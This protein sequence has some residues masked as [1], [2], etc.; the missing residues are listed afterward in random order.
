MKQIRTVGH[1][2]GRENQRRCIIGLS[3]FIAVLLSTTAP[4]YAPVAGP[5]EEY[6]CQEWCDPD[7]NPACGNDSEGQPRGPC[8]EHCMEASR[9]TCPG[10]DPTEA[11]HNSCCPCTPGCAGSL[12]DIS[13][14]PD[15]TWA[16][17]IRL[18]GTKVEPTYL[19][20]GPNDELTVT[21]CWRAE[22]QINRDYTFFVHLLDPD[23]NPLGQRD[24]HPGLGNFPTSTW[25][26]GDVFCDK[27]RVPVVEGVLRSPT[28]AN[29]EIGFY[30][31]KPDQRLPAQT[32][33]GQTLDFVVVDKVRISPHQ[34][35]EL[36]APVHR[37]EQAQFAQGVSLS[38]YAWQPEEVA[39]GQEATLRLWWAASGPLDADY[40]VFAHML[41]S[42]DTLISQA[43]GPPQG[44]RLP[45]NFWGEES[46]VDEHIFD[47]P[48]EVSPGPTTVQ[49][50]LYQLADGSR[51]PRTVDSEYASYVE[52]PGPNILR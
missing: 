40:Q 35:A 13:V 21:A 11:C 38:G 31:S 20:D 18:L 23:L 2:P 8:N 27:Y 22:N 39:P 52:I 49:V 9:A 51:L 28:V 25:Q 30:D 29:V 34:A 41:D 10:G 12:V 43:D 46:I 16:G 33:Q 24:M 47:I 32:G 3:V 4:L 5:C 42:S 19:T 50:G 44:G 26:K 37:F 36:P 1:F 14:Q 45:T 15:L 17:G 6:P 7:C 48:D